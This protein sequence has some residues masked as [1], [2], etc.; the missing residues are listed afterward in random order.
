[1]EFTSL[2]E[3]VKANAQE[4]NKSLVSVTQ[5]TKQ[6]INRYLRYTSS[7]NKPFNFNNY[8]EII[9]KLDDINLYFE[10]DNSNE[11]NLLEFNGYKFNSIELEGKDNLDSLKKY[12]AL[13]E[14]NKNYQIFLEN[15]SRK[16]AEIESQAEKLEFRLIQELKRKNEKS[17]QKMEQNEKEF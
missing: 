17:K 15:R 2:Y 11:F 10:I 5:L 13:N 6:K 4:N 14:L 9:N 12:Q 8:S 16:R 3:L 7:A 1:M